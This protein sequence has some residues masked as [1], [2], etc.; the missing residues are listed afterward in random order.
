M[1]RLKIAVF[2]ASG[3]VG[4]NI[5]SYFSQK[6]HNVYASTRKRDVKESWRLRSMP[7]G[8]F[9]LLPCDMSSISETRSAINAVRPDVV[10]NCSTYGGYYFEK[11]TRKI[12]GTNIIGTLNLL[13]S[14][15]NVPIFINTGTSS[16][17]GLRQTPMKESDKLA[18]DTDYGMSKALIT[19]IVSTHKSAITLRPFS[20]Y[21]YYEERYRLIPTLLYS[22][23]R[24]RRPALADKNNVRDYVFTEDLARAYELS[25]KNYDKYKGE[26]YNLAAGKQVRTIELVKML[27]LKA[28][29]NKSVHKKEPKR[30]WQADLS[31]IKAELGWQPKYS[32]S[33]GLKKTREWMEQNIALYEDERNDKSRVL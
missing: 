1:E 3:F 32:L 31:K 25:I 27:G 16:E 26:I 18:P 9:S 11:D 13:D 5:T 10:I 8:T 2:G 15:K 6:G 29:W 19:S 21:G 22:L 30:M 17:Y 12:I 33:E 24:H 20:V 4:A 23:I 7:K 28:E 14:S